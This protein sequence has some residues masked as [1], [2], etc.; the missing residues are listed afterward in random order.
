MERPEG[1]PLDVYNLMLKC[2]DWKPGDRP[3]FAEIHDMMNNMFQNSNIDEEVE[4][5]LKRRKDP[6]SL[7]A[8]QRS[9]RRGAGGG[10]DGDHGK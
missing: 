6:P 1:C 10:G 2:W 9:I 5:S 8:K 3:D 4:K 7:P